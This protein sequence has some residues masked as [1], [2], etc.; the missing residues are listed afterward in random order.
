MGTGGGR[1]AQ[2]PS[3][4]KT[5]P[6][7]IVPGRPSVLTTTLAR[8]VIGEG[9]VLKEGHQFPVV[10]GIRRCCALPRPVTSR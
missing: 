2:G 1:G 6:T 10:V 7:P 3:D 9:V 8:P 4:D 5:A